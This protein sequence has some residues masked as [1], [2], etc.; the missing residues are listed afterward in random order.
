M[1]FIITFMKFLNTATQLVS[2][3]KCLRCPQST[4]PSIGG[5][6]VTAQH[7]GGGV[8]EFEK[9]RT[10]VTTLPNLTSGKVSS[11]PPVVGDKKVVDDGD[12]DEE[13]EDDMVAPPPHTHTPLPLWEILIAS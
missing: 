12:V 8:K 10:T 13:D 11:L 7:G 3:R 1:K 4:L 9:E 5:G 6:H 2:T